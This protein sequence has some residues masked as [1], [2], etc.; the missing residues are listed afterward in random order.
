MISD[1]MDPSLGKIFFFYFLICIAEGV[2]SLPQ[3]RNLPL[4]SMLRKNG[5]RCS[6]FSDIGFPITIIIMNETDSAL[7]CLGLQ[8]QVSLESFVECWSRMKVKVK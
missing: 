6:M 4:H 7:Q 8:K 5:L 1:A 2:C 3:I